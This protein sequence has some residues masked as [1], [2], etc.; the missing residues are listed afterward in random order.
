MS[1]LS[2]AA[3]KQNAIDFSSKYPLAAEVT[4]KSIYVDDCLTGAYTV[5]ESVHPQVE[6]Q[7]LFNEARFMLHKW[8][9]S[10]MAVLEQVPSDLRESHFSQMISDQSEFSK[11]L[12][13]EWNSKKDI[14]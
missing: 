2:F 14:F 12:G 3:L 13:I 1:H 10:D 9:S 6:L 7:G 8:N 11:T 4:K 5:E